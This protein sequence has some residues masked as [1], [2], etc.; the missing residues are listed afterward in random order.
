MVSIF[1][2]ATFGAII[3]W[4]AAILQDEVAPRRVVAYIATGAIGGLVGGF[5][6][7][8]LSP[9]EAAYRAN[10]TDI[11]FAVFGA[12]TFVFMAGV[13]AQKHSGE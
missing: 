12:T 8:I 6:G 9:D 2:W 5:G 11:M 13:A 10:T 7:L 3:G 1:F 4:I